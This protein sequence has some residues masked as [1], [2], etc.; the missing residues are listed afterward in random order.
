MVA[1]VGLLLLLLVGGGL[2]YSLLPLVLLC[3]LAILAFALYDLRLALLLCVA[4]VPL[5]AEVQ[6]GSIGTDL[7]LEPILILTAGL[8]LVYVL[9]YA[10][11][12]P[13]SV[14]RHPVS[15]LL[16]VHV[17]WIAITALAS[18]VPLYSWKYLAAKLWYVLPWYVLGGLLL[19]RP[20]DVR[21]TVLC[22]A[23]PLAVALSYTVGRHASLDFA[24]DRVN[25][26]MYPFFRN[27][28]SYAALPSI[29]LPFVFVGAFLFGKRSFVRWGLF[30][31]S[32]LLILAVQTS[33]T[34]A[35]YVS[36]VAGVAFTLVL[37]WRLTR[38]V[39][40]ATVGTAA[41]F[42]TYLVSDN[43]FLH[44]APDYNKAI[45]QTDFQSL[46]EATYK[47]EDVST[48]ERVYRWVA[49]GYMAAEEPW[50][51]FGP[52]TFVSQYRGYAIETFRTYVSDNLEGS[53]VHSY[54][55]MVLVEQGWIGL[56]VFLALCGVAL[57]TAERAYHSAASR[58]ERLIVLMAA[59]SLVINL[60]FQ[61]IN[62]MIET[63]KAGPWFFYS[64]A[65]IVAVDLRQRRRG[66]AAYV[67]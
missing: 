43:N 66:P 33:Y 42:F 52:G 23:V 56:F 3:G 53:G 37:R 50:L 40:L 47:L 4:L 36:I 59:S 20:R 10:R 32:A 13:G 11:Q 45:T 46:V 12:L 29:T 9:R 35:A 1:G 19:S 41:L 21:R 49:A 39:L 63:D 24:F 5:S 67:S 62:D 14:I 16:L 58:E 55:F 44:F 8:G 51:G 28:V 27:H 30:G 31:V 6:I 61:L 22:L 57:T 17:T 60:S 15:L 25:E 18:Q 54:Y 65:L 26:A 7:P 38:V 48:M 2:A 34:R 64:L